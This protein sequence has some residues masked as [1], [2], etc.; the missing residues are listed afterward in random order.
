MIDIKKTKKELAQMVE[1]DQKLR[2]QEAPDSEINKVDEYNRNRFKEIFQE[3]GLIAIS[4]YGKKTSQ[5]AWLLVQH[6]PREELTFME[7]YLQ[8]MKENSNDINVINMAY[9]E[10]RVLMYKGM[11]QIYGTQLRW[12]EDKQKYLLWKLQDERNVNK[13]RKKIGLGTIEEYLKQME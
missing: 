9:L 2:K 10:D 8:L 12:N 11:P 5:N 6:F 1:S 13:I 4:K 7:N 3:T